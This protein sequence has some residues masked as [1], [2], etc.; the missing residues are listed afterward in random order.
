MKVCTLVI[1]FLFT[2]NN[3]AKTSKLVW[4]DG[5]DIEKLEKTL[6]DDKF[7]AEIKP[8]NCCKDVTIEMR[9]FP[10]FDCRKGPAQ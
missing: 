8:Q 5:R 2:L 3:G 1:S 7:I 4:L 6:T 9:D 10:P